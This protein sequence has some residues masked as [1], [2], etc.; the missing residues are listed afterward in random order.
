MK[1]LQVGEFKRNFSEILDTVRD[2]EEVTITYGKK[3][4]KVAILIPYEKY[5]KKFKRK[6][7]LLADK[8][9][10]RI[11]EDFEISDEDLLS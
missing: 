4:E 9:S 8:A 3:K 1:T 7:G 10:C 2:G 11:N 6:L 5:H